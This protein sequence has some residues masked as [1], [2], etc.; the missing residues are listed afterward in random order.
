MVFLRVCPQYSSITMRVMDII[1]VSNKSMIKVCQI[2]I[3]MVWMSLFASWI[4][5]NTFMNVHEMM[6][7][8][9]VAIFAYNGELDLANYYFNTV[10]PTYA[11]AYNWSSYN[12]AVT[13]CQAQHP[14]EAA[15]Q[16]CQTKVNKEFAKLSVFWDPLRN[17]SLRRHHPFVDCQ[18]S[19][20][21]VGAKLNSEE[22]GF[23]NRVHVSN[24]LEFYSYKFH[25]RQTCP[26]HA[27][28][29]DVGG[30]TFDMFAYS[31]QSLATCTSKDLFDG[32]YSILC[33]V[34]AFPTQTITSNS[35][36][37]IQLSVN[38]EHEHYDA[39][40]LALDA[41]IDTYPNIREP[42]VNNVTYCTAAML[43]P[44]LP[45][46]T[47][48]SSNEDERQHRFVR[49]STVPDPLN[50]YVLSIEGNHHYHHPTHRP[51][52][53]Y[54]GIWMRQEPDDDYLLGGNCNV[55]FGAYVESCQRNFDHNRCQQS[56]LH[57]SLNASRAAS[58]FASTSKSRYD[59][60]SMWVN[61]RGCFSEVYSYKVEHKKLIAPDVGT[62]AVASDSQ[63]PLL[64]SF[65]PIHMALLRRE[66]AWTI[67]GYS[68]LQ[69]IHDDSTSIHF[70]GASHMRYLFMGT[71]EA[72]Y[73]GTEISK[74][75]RK[76][77]NGVFNSLR[78]TTTHYADD[79][80]LNI[81]KVCE[82]LTTPMGRGIL[83]LQTGDW[84]LSV[85]VSR[86]LKDSSYL[87]NLARVLTDV[88]EGRTPC[89]SIHHII[90]I[91]GLPYPLCNAD[92]DAD[93]CGDQRCFR[94]NTAV[95]ALNIYIL[96]RLLNVTVHP[97]MKLSIV[98][99]YSII[100]PRIMLNENIETTCS[101]H[102]SC[103]VEGRHRRTHMVYSPSGMAIFQSLLHALSN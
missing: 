73:G 11:P 77:S 3:W 44:S 86:A 30:S 6:V 61:R 19:I 70:I 59:S 15:L 91:T 7:A 63:L 57:D 33:E 71:I 54:S 40:S 62:H 100:I 4:C 8:D 14:G 38:L 24:W 97:G 18:Y 51:V 95:A 23:M 87:A 17:Y 39:F 13:E 16:D 76:V 67:A 58:L 47:E 60:A 74:F 68:N 49:R 81:R 43:Q 102:F 10:L 31:E 28:L 41:W 96:Q 85:S 83:V 79:L 20:E 78:F 103:A 5:L 72:I 64:Y 32:N 1:V 75:D 98:D 45:S 37:C 101:N 21:F 90:F 27:R 88:L 89:P 56:W 84:D 93:F 48:T 82:N 69:Q 55:N 12:I 66:M 9:A 36:H 80:A 29:Q 2:V 26:A 34:P 94:T 46:F 53:M 52:V 99:A 65:R 50:Q 35:Q 22:D 42:I 92:G 25:V